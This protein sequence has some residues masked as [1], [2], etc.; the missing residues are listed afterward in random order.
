MTLPVTAQKLINLNVKILSKLTN[1]PIPFAFVTTYNNGK[2]GKSFQGDLNGS[3][4]LKLNRAKSTIITAVNAGFITKDTLVAINSD[5]LEIKIFLD[6][7]PEE[8]YRDLYNRQ[9]A[10]SDLKK[11]QVKILFVGL[12]FNKDLQKIN[13]CCR[14]YGFTYTRTTDAVSGHL[15]EAVQNYNDVVIRY[16][17]LINDAD[18]ADQLKKS[19]GLTLK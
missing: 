13:E 1:E 14:K 17:D 6:S 7:A 4:S 2:P 3:V 19:C 16:L 10:Y 9:S 8:D 15:R 12:V 18:W 11:G 5:S